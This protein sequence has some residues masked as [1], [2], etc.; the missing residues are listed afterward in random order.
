MILIP[1]PLLDR[2]V[3]L[4]AGLVFGDEA[5]YCGLAVQDTTPGFS[6]GSRAYHELGELEFGDGQDGG[7]QGAG[8]QKRRISLPATR[9]RAKYLSLGTYH[10]RLAYGV[11]CQSRSASGSS[12]VERLGMRPISD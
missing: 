5:A 3:G 12:G 1:G 7:P 10:T 11:F 6:L 8:S 4:Q 9:T 2:I